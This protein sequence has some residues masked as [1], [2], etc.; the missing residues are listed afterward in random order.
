[1]AALS[2]EKVKL[3][4]GVKAEIDN[5]LVT[6]IRTIAGGGMNIPQVDVTS[7]G[8]KQQE[9]STGRAHFDPLRLTFSNSKSTVPLL[10]K[11]AA[12]HADPQ[13]SSRHTIAVTEITRDG[14]TTGHAVTYYECFCTKMRLPTGN[15]QDG[16]LNTELEFSLHRAEH[17]SGGIQ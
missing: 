12:Y 8:S 13:N 15:N 4:Q 5:Q 2:T 14:A 10:Q 16:V 9:S 3:R 6:H 1:M 11:I 17:N 7:S